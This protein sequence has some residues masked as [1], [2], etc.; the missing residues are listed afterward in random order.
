[1]P[2][3]PPSNSALDKGSKDLAAVVRRLNA[4]INLLS[5]SKVEK[6][7]A[8]SDRIR[9]LKESGLTNPEIGQIVGK[10]PNYVGVVSARKPKSKKVKPRK[11]KQ[12]KGAK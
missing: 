9:L 5:R 3:K 6:A 2:R 11:G 8:I 12:R 10:G 7:P 4:I 1:M